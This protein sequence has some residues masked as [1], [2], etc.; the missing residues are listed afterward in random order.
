MIFG[1]KSSTI[2]ARRFGSYGA[3]IHPEQTPTISGSLIELDGTRVPLEEQ[4]LDRGLERTIAIEQQFLGSASA[5]GR[6]CRLP[7]LD[8]L[9]NIGVPLGG[10]REKI[11]SEFREP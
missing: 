5:S 10:R 2:R 3:R 4:A 1:T 8:D 7:P 6:P 11:P 9:G